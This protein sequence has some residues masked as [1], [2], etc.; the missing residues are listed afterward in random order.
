[1]RSSCAVKYSLAVWD[2]HTANRE[3]RFVCLQA[4]YHVIFLHRVRSIQPFAR[5]SPEFD[6]AETHAARTAHLGRHSMDGSGGISGGGGGGGGG[7]APSRASSF[8][9]AEARSSDGGAAA[10]GHAAGCRHMDVLREGG[11]QGGGRQ[12]RDD[13]QSAAAAAAAAA[14]HTACGSRGRVG[15]MESRGLLR[16]PFVTLF[17]YLRVRGVAKKA[18]LARSCSILFAG[19]GPGGVPSSL[20]SLHTWL[21]RSLA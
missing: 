20:G 10:G 5:D 4:G 15:A 9:G 8:G 7:P 21:L 12:S 13:S 6:P 11:E 17:E 16:V 3:L 18:E 19:I 1:M 2:F 14:A